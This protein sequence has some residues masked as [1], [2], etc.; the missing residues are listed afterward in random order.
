MSNCSAHTF[1]F[2]LLQP[3]LTFPIFI[4]FIDQHLIRHRGG[5]HKFCMIDQKKRVREKRKIDKYQYLQ[6]LA[7]KE[8]GTIHREETVKFTFA[9]QP[10]WQQTFHEK[11][12]IRSTKSSFKKM[13][14]RLR[15]RNYPLKFSTIT[16]RGH[17]FCQT[18]VLGYQS[19]PSVSGSMWWNSGYY[20][21][22]FILTSTSGTWDQI[23]KRPW[24][25]NK[26]K[27]NDP[28]LWKYIYLEDS[29]LLGVTQGLK[30]SWMLVHCTTVTMARKMMMKPTAILYHTH[31]TAIE[32]CPTSVP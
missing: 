26:L 19:C 31:F 6:G 27:C 20:V 11:R 2:I 21:Q 24:G 30:I 8:N 16:V 18:R 7:S 28:Q 13:Y 5:I 10:E 12:R 32:K 23:V 15:L 22:K 25:W 9:V 29:L 17:L 3:T 1:T 4:L 14:W